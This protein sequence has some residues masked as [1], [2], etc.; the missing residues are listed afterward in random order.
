MGESRLTGLA[1]LHTHKDIV[2]N[3]ENVINRFANEKKR[4]VKLL[5]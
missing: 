1:L 4:N 3:I 5:L 2:V